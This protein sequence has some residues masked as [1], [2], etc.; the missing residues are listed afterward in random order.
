MSEGGEVTP[1][2]ASGSLLERGVP[3]WTVAAIALIGLIGSVLFAWTARKDAEGKDLGP[4]TGVVRGIST[5]PSAILLV[6]KQLRDDISGKS[7]D[8]WVLVPRLKKDYTSFKPVSQSSG[9]KLAGL[10]TSGT[11][12]DGFLILTGAFNINGGMENAAVLLK[13]PEMSVD[14]IWILD[15]IAKDGFKPAPPTNKLVHGSVLLPDHS[16]VVTFDEGKTIQRFDG[17]GKRVW[18]RGGD[19][20]H[21]VNAAPDGKSVWTLDMADLNRIRIS[22]GKVLQ[23]I[24]VDQLIEAN[25]DI[26]PLN[27]LQDS[28]ARAGT[29]ARSVKESWRPS[30][31]HFNDVDPLP[32][33]LASAFPEFKVG[34]LV[35]SSRTLNLVMVVDPDTRKIKWWRAGATERQHD[36]NW[37]PDGTIGVFNNRMGRSFSRIDA[38]DPKTYKVSVRFDGARNDFFSRIRG[39]FQQLE[40]GSLL[41]TSPEQ[42]RGFLADTNGDIRFEL[43]NHKPGEAGKNYGITS[44]QWLPTNYFRPEKKS[45]SAA[46]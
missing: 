23:A 42:G 12:P 14:R 4:A 16:L 11:M 30:P 41:I 28:P 24:S 38:I 8:K 29:N 27:M 2:K 9:P 43:D 33:E 26:S 18:A 3:L 21:A 36:P 46:N 7:A 31:W 40:D 35:V 10:T 13:S 44:M 5:F 32:E 25:P 20:N 45:C 17:C 39:R 22:D 6:F 19:Y 15:E 1:D 37:L 34:D